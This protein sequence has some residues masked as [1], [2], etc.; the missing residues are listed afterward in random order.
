MF[1]GAG[2]VQRAMFAFIVLTILSCL[3][4]GAFLGDSDYGVMRTLTYFTSQGSGIWVVPLGAIGFLAALPQMLIWDYSFWH[5]IGFGGAV[6]RLILA[7]TISIGFVWGVVTMA[8]PIVAN[9]FVSLLKGVGNL[10]GR[11]I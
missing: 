10:L 3:F 5:S 4:Q 6:I 2:Y 1:F 8:W 9:L 11:F 7:A